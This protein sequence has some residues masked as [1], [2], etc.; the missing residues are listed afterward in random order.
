M[1]FVTSI[2]LATGALILGVALIAFG[3]SS[4]NKGV[5]K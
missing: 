1:E 2:L 4:R 3:L 5:K